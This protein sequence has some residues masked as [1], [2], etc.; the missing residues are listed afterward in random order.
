MFYACKKNPFDSA[1]NKSSKARKQL[2]RRHPEER[3]AGVPL[4]DADSA[5]TVQGS[6]SVFAAVLVL[7]MYF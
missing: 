6:S 1:L 3:S 4:L 7:Q 5:R 2:K